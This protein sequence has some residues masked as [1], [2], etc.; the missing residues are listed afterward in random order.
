MRIRWS[1]LRMSVPRG[2]IA[3]F[4]YLNQV[5]TLSVLIFSNN[6]YLCSGS[7]I[8]TLRFRFHLRLLNGL[9][10]NQSCVCSVC[11]QCKGNVRGACELHGPLLPCLEEI[12]APG[13][14]N[15]SKFPVPSFIEI[16]ESTIPGAGDGTF[17]SQF[18]EPGRILGKNSV[19]SNTVP[20]Y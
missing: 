5:L 12:T 20:Q 15:S 4:I 7:V 8:F 9:L 6:Y 18:I 16:K 1:L 2:T 11:W 14:E 17:A 10:I 19:L 13:T 3:R